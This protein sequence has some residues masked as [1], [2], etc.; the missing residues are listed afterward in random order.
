MKICERGLNFVQ[1]I[2]SDG[3]VRICGWIND[4]IIGNLQT[5]T[6][7]QIWNG[8]KAREIRNQLAK[9]DYSNC[10]VDA[11]P[12]LANH[13][14]CDHLV[15]FDEKN[16]SQYP[17]ELQLGFEKICNYSC[18]SCDVSNC[19]K[20]CDWEVAERNYKIIED[21]LRP[22]L[23]Y[24]KKIGA[25]G[26]GELFCSK[27]I[28]KILSEWRP[29][30]PVNEIQV[31]LETNGSLF[32]EEHWKQI[33]NL[34]QYNLFVAITIMSFD[35]RTY[36]YLSGT[37]LPISNIENNLRFV[38]RLREKNIIN[39]L[40]LATVL[41][42]RNFRTLP[43]FVRRCIDEFGADEVRVRPYMP[44]GAKEPELEWFTDV[45]GK[46]HPYHAEY[47]EVMKDP[48]FKNPKVKDW[49]GGLDSQLGEVF[50]RR[51]KSEKKCKM[52]VNMLLED[53]W[54]EEL[55]K[56]CEKREVIIYGVGELGKVIIKQLTGKASIPYILDRASYDGTFLAIPVV[57]PEAM[58]CLKRDLPILITPLEVLDEV[59]QYLRGLGYSG[60]CIGVEELIS[61]K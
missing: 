2:N 7:E 15:E 51:K 27:H 44:W 57:Q 55:L 60:E 32:D 4:N 17:I 39:H 23:P 21:R 11:C 38:K 58:D 52:L 20:V 9:D 56:R 50:S 19:M 25:N 53:S 10:I 37:N 34:G 14:V 3:D 30:V 36:Q 22:V 16:P 13:T 28:L 18:T 49:S 40:Q 59:K 5:E 47:L 29:I 31:T 46:Y 61:G 45:R 33:E 41:Q 48:I 35:E 42:E 8:K 54:I 1:I 43:S 24:V 12:W 6:M 26:C